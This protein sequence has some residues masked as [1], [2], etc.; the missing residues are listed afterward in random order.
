MNYALPVYDKQSIMDCEIPRAQAL[1]KILPPKP[2]PNPFLSLWR[3]PIDLPGEI[4]I[5]GLLGR[6]SGQWL[7]ACRILDLTFGSDLDKV[8]AKFEWEPA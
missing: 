1:I 3:A 7:T 6:L 2:A 5:I 4:A 8:V